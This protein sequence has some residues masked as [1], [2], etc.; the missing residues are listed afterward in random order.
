MKVFTTKSKKSIYNIGVVLF[1]I[2]VWEILFLIINREIYLPSPFETVKSLFRLIKAKIFWN[3]IFA[4][5][6]RV[7]LG[8]FLSCFLGTVLG[9]ICGLNKYIY[10]IFQPLMVTIKSTPVM[11]FIIIAL[12]WF[13]SD[14]VPVFICFLICFPI[15]WTSTVKG[16]NEVDFKLLEMAKVY[17]VKKIHIIEKIYLPSIVPYL[18]ASMVTALGIGWKATVAAEVLSNPKLSIGAR[19]YDAKV[20]LES[21]NLFAWT[22]VVVLLSMLFEYVFK[23]LMGRFLYSKNP[24]DV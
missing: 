18:S 3:T 24:K 21:E 20:Y 12:I 8:F 7:I 1:W 17:S 23:I 15:I 13:K 22:L 9:V 4:T 2:T 10:W 16:I 6:G 14:I 11:S 5:V 19:L